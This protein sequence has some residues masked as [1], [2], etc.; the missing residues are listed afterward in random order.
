MRFLPRSLLQP[1]PLFVL[2]T[3]FLLTA[4]TILP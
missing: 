3:Y 4:M 1:R 2:V